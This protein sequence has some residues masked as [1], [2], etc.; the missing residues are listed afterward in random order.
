M[1]DTRI[2]SLSA[3]VQD[4]TAPLNARFRALFE[5]RDIGGASVVQQLAQV[6]SDPSALLKHEIAYVLGQMRD[7]AA[8]PVLI[9]V[10]EDLQE[11]VMVRHEAAE[12]LGA[13]G[14]A[15]V[16]PVLQ[17]FLEDEAEEVRQTCEL[18]IRRVEWELANPDQ[19]M[20]NVKS[21]VYSSVDPAPPSGK[22]KRGSSEKKKGVPEL[23]AILLDS[24]RQL[25]K[26]YKA[27][28]ALRDLGTEEAVLALCD[29][30][31]D[32]SALFRHEVAF[33]LGQMEHPASV[34]TLERV[35][36]N[37]EE[38]YMVRHEAAEAL[39]GIC[40]ASCL[41][42]L[43]QYKEDS[44]RPVAES[45]VVALDMYDYWSQWKNKGEAPADVSVPAE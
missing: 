38:H 28:F 13:L 44:Q 23:R 11:D 5:L 33:V 24:T 15:S 43:R 12:A 20:E 4:A 29:G 18:A 16:L 7:A 42:T 17:R 40:D 39:G 41:D 10:L 1:E 8:I 25:F 9:P 32:P 3:V 31:S 36:G 34:P 27:M 2:A 21:G 6:F 35:L 37:T 45:C 19:A 14:D 30:F 22:S 26:R